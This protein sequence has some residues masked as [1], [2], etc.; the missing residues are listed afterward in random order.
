MRLPS[1]YLNVF[2]LVVAFLLWHSVTLAQ[3]SASPP[4]EA[5]EYMIYQYPGMALVVIVDVREAEFDTR[6]TGPEGTLVSE[7]T[8]PGRLIGPVYQ[9]IAAVDTPRQLMVEVRPQQK[10]QRSRISMK[11]LQFP[12]QDPNAQLQAKAYRMLSHGMERVYRP[13]GATWAE[14][15]SSLRNAAR[16]FASMGNE[17]MQLWSEYYAAHL[18][19]HG[20]GDVLLARERAR[21]VHTAARRA[22]LPAIELLAALLEA[23][24]LMRE[25]ERSVG[26]QATA[27]YEQAHPLWEQV[28]A[29]AE[30]LGFENERGRS[31]YR[32]GIAYER[33]DRL[34][35]AIER[36]EQALAVIAPGPD[37]ELLNTV[38]ATA[39]AAYERSGST[40]GALGLLEDITG[41]LSER[42]EAAMALELAHN[43][44]ERGRL[45]N[46]TF[47]FAEAL[48]VLERALAL[49]QRH[50]ASEPWG[51]TGLELGRSQFALGDF[52][53]AV[54]TLN[55]ALPRTPRARA[56]E[57]YRALGALASIAR[58]RGRHAESAEYRRRQE[59][60][61]WA[62]VGRA[63]FLYES[64]M[65]ARARG[66]SAE[67]LRLLGDARAEAKGRDRLTEH[68]AGLQRCLLL[69]VSGRGSCPPQQVRESLAVL[70]RSGLPSLEVE[71]GLAWVQLL[72]REGRTDQA[73]DEVNG[74]LDTVQFYRERLPGVIVHWHAVNRGELFS[75]YL[76]LARGVSALETL[77]ALENIRR[78]EGLVPQERSPE[79]AVRA[80]VQRAMA[81]QPTAIDVP[82]RQAH[83][84]IRRFRE[85]ADWG[86]TRPTTADIRAALAQLDRRTS[87]L[88]FDFSGDRV[89][90][91]TA[92]HEGARLHRLADSARTRARL[93]EAWAAI[94]A[95]EA[96]VEPLLDRLGADLLAPLA[97]A[98]GETIL[99]MPSGPV[100]GFPLDALRVEGRFLAARHR[101]VN[102]DSVIGLQPALEA[103]SNDFGQQVFLAGNPRA[104]R[105]L[106]SYG[107]TTSRQIDAVRDRF[108][109]DGL[110]IVQGVALRGDEFQ[111]GRYA[112]ASLIHLTMPGRV[113]LA[114]PDDS[115][116]LLSGERESPAADFLGP[117]DLRSIPLR[118][119]LAVLAGTAFAG[120]KAPY[121]ASRLGLLHDLNRAGA[122]RV[123]ASLWPLDDERSAEFMEAFYTR[124]AQEKDV[125]RA[126]H[127]TRKALLGAEN[128]PNL[129]Q[130]AGFQ[131]F[132]R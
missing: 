33:Q 76:E 105:E 41:D 88:A 66:D 38:R 40:S 43:L 91:V 6:I 18:V 48:P 2:P 121:F 5:A 93:D 62:E 90:A 118:A 117:A 72:Q 52:D 82:S 37:Q 73:R 116:L 119:E 21:R 42:D 129:V 9:Y 69:R 75:A 22:G 11:L 50:G 26:E 59:G 35:S 8:V 123:I 80:A 13:S 15:T 1:H 104:G 86:N 28:A 30:V 114:H 27:R 101:L 24:S 112:N 45:L 56:V 108:V 70:K 3:T 131:L 64:A 130:W 29:M 36:Y 95:P 97:D 17:E 98:I 65:D 67:A 51:P 46:E 113:D 132:I 99:L 89:H 47:R 20:V 53:S 49:R 12:R 60:A 32:D 71:A 54:Q 77:R 44:H 74:L 10:V 122:S 34:D 125:A 61:A 94:Q 4:A 57:R 81:A 106:F 110:H 58:D 92:S 78:L 83:G 39:A 127:D 103:L 7:A 31:L 120:R 102:I 111:D 85:R 96:V 100:N 124:L 16:V 25:A 84:A 19:L 87:V 107:V 126:L 14:R 109:G 128:G 115:R 68:R 55:D 63:A 23:E 79:D